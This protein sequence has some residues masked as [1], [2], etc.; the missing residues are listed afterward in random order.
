MRTNR[1]NSQ[2]LCKNL[3]SAQDCPRISIWAT[4]SFSRV[5]QEAF[6]DQPAEAALLQET[7]LRTNLQ[8]A[9]AFQSKFKLHKWE[10]RC[11]YDLP[12]C[13]PLTFFCQFLITRAVCTFFLPQCSSPQRLASRSN[14]ALHKPMLCT[15]RGTASR[16]SECSTWLGHN[17]ARIRCPRFNIASLNHTCLWSSVN[18]LKLENTDPQTPLFFIFNHRQLCTRHR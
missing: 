6:H 5:D 8:V 1:M 16:P 14:T 13:A 15:T 7:V 4:R 2:V 12:S 3:K 17:N 18:R 10:L 9:Q 11:F